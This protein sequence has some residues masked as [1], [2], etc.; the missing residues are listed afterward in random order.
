MAL[1]TGANITNI[2]VAA[3][4]SFSAGVEI[5]NIEAA[6]V[7]SFPAGVEIVNIAA[8]AVLQPIPLSN[9]PR[10]GSIYL[11]DGVVGVPYRTRFDLYPA[12]TPLTVTLD[13]G[14]FPPGSPAF[15]LVL[16]SGTIW[17]LQGTP[18]VAGPY[19]FTLRATNSM[20]TDT[21]TF[22]ISMFAAAGAG[23]AWAWS[24]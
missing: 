8:A 6:A 12:S 11:P 4:L 15:S 9:P 17:E 16:I 13:S 5:A 24:E 19:T 23:K 7:L 14:S 20:G 1:G 3:V 18:T 2:E 21:D 22:T 10:W